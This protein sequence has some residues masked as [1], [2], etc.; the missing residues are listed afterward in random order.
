MKKIKF[1]VCLFFV[2]VWFFMP[3]CAQ[4]FT[5]SAQT[6]ATTLTLPDISIRKDLPVGS[7]IGNLITTDFID[8]YK[9]TNTAP[10]ITSQSFGIKAAGTYVTKIDGKRIYATGVEG[11]G[12]AIQGQSGNTCGTLAWVDGT[13]MGDT[14]ANN[15]LFCNANGLLSTQAITGQIGIQLYKTAQVTGSGSV[16]SRQVGSFIIFNNRTSWTQPE[17]TVSINSFNIKTL[18][19]SVD[20]STIS[21]VMGDVDRNAF[22]GVGS[23]PGDARTK[24]FTIPLTCAAETRVTVQ[25]DGDTPN[26]AEGLLNLTASGNSAT[27]AAVQILHDSKPLALGSKVEIGLSTS[28]SN[29][30]AFQARY[31]Q[32]S[33]DITPG[34][35]N[36]TA[37]FTLTYQ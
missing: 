10:L 37:T 4:A 29:S 2:S 21:V 28:G 1:K 16:R 25:I 31:Y 34:K 30:L 27:G 13:N 33:N 14:N 19:C 11:V 5:C 17:P 15:R 26:A 8:T 36:A 9:C 7:P 23:W 24:V 22:K 18:T 12:Y 35:A 3:F 6:T 32:T 20:S